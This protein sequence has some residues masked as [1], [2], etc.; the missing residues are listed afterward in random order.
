MN[1]RVYDTV[2]VGAGPIGCYSAY[3]L[4]TNGYDV[5]V[6]EKDGSPKAPPVCTGVIGVQAFREFDLP[7]DSILS[8]VKDIVL[9]SPSGKRITYRPPQTQAYVVD[10]VA[11][12]GTLKREAER[13]GASFLEG[14]VCKDIKITDDHVEMVTSLRGKPII[15]RTLV[16][17][18]GY[19]P[20]LVAK[21]G[22]GRIPDHFE[23]IQTEARVA[24]LSDTE[25]YV[26][27][28][29]APFSFAWMLPLGSGSARIGLT[30][31]RNGSFFLAQFL[32]HPTVRDRIGEVGHF[33][34]N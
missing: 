7:R 34:E 8:E 9:L 33:L 17:A 18:S 4:A 12:D 14:V 23:G 25:I 6:V 22:L 26:G 28:S 5:L 15:A 20:G 1:Q 3:G 31:K 11:F 24:D 2:V 19:H 16:L 27:R 10:R 32:G 13:A 21:L 30:T 29:V